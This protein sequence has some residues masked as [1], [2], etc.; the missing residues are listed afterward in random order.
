M[1]FFVVLLSYFIGSISFGYLIARSI[2]KVDIRKLGSGNPGATNIQRVL[3]LRYAVIVL[4]LDVLKGL[5]VVILAFSFLAETWV[6]LLAC[7]AVIAGH[8]WPI[9]FAFKGGRGVATT[10]GVFLGLAPLPTVVVFIIAAAV[11]AVTRYVSLGSITGA[12]SIPVYMLA[13]KYPFEYLVF[14]FIVSIFIIWRH[15]PNIKRLIQGRELKLGEKV[16]IS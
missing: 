16:N 13:L 1:C 15:F 2:K 6:I 9:F 14:G 5:V 3:G 4:L 12:V 11:I 8:N 10:L 7:L